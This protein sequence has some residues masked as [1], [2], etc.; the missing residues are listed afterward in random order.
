MAAMVRSIRNIEK[1]LG[2]SN[3]TVSNSE[4]EN[5]AVVRKSIVAARNIKK[6]EILTADNLTTK[7]PGTGISPMRWNDVLGRKAIRDFV[8]DEVI[9]I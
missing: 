1:A 5:I 7:R 9:E 3:K 2:S 8:E 6:G 4:R